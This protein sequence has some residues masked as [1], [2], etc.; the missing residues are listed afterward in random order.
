MAGEYPQLSGQ[1]RIV[2]TAEDT[3][4]DISFETYLRGELKTYSMETLVRYGQLVAAYAG[5]G[6]NMVEEIIAR[7]VRLYGYSDMRQAEN[8]VERQE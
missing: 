1:A 8:A 7:T 6:K 4:E 2:H 5:N 3:A